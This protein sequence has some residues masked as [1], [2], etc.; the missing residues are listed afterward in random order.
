MTKRPDVLASWDEPQHDP[1]T[2]PPDD[3][4]EMTLDEAVEAIEEW[5]FENFENPA[6][7][8]PHDSGEG[9]YQYIWGGPYDTRDIVENVFADSASDELITAAIEALN[10]ESDVWVPSIRRR[11]APDDEYM[12]DVAADPASLHAELQQRLSALEEAV[13]A[14]P[15]SPPG[16]GH[17]NPPEAIEA[18]AYTPEDRTEIVVAIAVLKAQPVTPPDDGKAAAESATVLERKASKFRDWLTRQGDNFVTE[19]VKESGKKLAQWGWPLIFVG[20]VELLYGVSGLVTKW[21]A[22]LGLGLPL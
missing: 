18:V 10:L 17:N 20:I 7:S 5:F 12:P 6:N 22:A 16:S 19:F 13:A 15:A 2:I 3:F 14:L 4:S 1:L 9:G 21:L 8:T 11:R